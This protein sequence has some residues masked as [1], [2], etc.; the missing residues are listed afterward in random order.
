[1]RVMV[2]STKCQGIGMCEAHIPDLLEIQSG[3]YAVVLQDD[4]AAHLEADVRAAIARCPTE[5]ISLAD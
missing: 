1:M 3:G 5:S 2:N 4:V